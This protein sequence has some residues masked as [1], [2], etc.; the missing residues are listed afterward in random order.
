MLTLDNHL[1]T[2]IPGLLSLSLS[3]APPPVQGS[4]D[5]RYV[6]SASDC[7]SPYVWR[8]RRKDRRFDASKTGKQI[9]STLLV[10]SLGLEFLFQWTWWWFSF[11]IAI[12]RCGR[13]HFYRRLGD[14]W[15]AAEQADGTARPFIKAWGRANNKRRVLQRNRDMWN[16]WRRFFPNL[17]TILVKSQ[18]SICN[19]FL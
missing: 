14:L 6:P 9:M 10:S 8:R 7:F 16:I 15:K 4:L 12:G 19:R 13:S 2:L 5:G 11:L 18:F 3:V 17:Y 1:H